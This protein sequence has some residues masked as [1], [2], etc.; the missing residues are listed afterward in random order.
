MRDAAG[1][2]R[3]YVIGTI[4]D[5]DVVGWALEAAASGDT[6]PEIEALSRYEP[7]DPSS[8][9]ARLTELLVAA[10]PGADGVTVIEHRLRHEAA[11][12]L[13]GQASP[14][15]FCTLVREFEADIEDRGL[16]YPDWIGDLWHACDW[17]DETWT[18]DNAGA[19]K[20]GAEKLLG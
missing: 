9:T 15:E 8:N 3:D 17:C 12:L 4:G 5:W 14:I 1:I 7:G 20:A 2:L 6:T 13:A 11:R 16:P 10:V 19:L 18:L